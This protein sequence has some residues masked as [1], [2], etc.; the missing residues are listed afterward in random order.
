M[1]HFVLNARACFIWIVKISLCFLQ[2]G[3]CGSELSY[4]TNF[5]RET[6]E[7]GLE[8]KVIGGDTP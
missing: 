5:V 8:A 3:E 6:E 2:Q 7:S 4:H 1:A